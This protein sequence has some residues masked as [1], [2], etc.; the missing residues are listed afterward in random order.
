M[1]IKIPNNL[2]SPTVLI[3]G[4]RKV[5][6]KQNVY[7][8]KRL[9]MLER[10]LDQQYKSFIDKS[11]NTKSI[12]QMQKS[13][14]SILD[15]FMQMNKA[16]LT[17]S[18]KDKMD[19]L[20][21]EFDTRIKALSEND[22]GALLDSFSKKIGK[23]ESAINRLASKDSEV[24]VSVTKPI[25]HDYLSKSFD[26]FYEKMQNLVEKARPRMIPYVS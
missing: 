6:D 24:K 21:R 22:N 14:A 4:Q 11:D 23:L 10:K 25:S 8:E 18:H 5:D 16:M 12:E 2:E 15:K 13:F 3:I 9:D 17:S 20:R 19:S 1:N 7:Q 26:T